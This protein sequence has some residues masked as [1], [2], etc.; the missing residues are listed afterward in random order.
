MYGQSKEDKSKLLDS[1]PGWTAVETFQ[2]EK[3]AHVTVTV[4]SCSLLARGLGRC[5]GN[6]RK[7]RK[8]I[9]PTRN[10]HLWRLFVCTSATYVH[11]TASNWLD[12]FCCHSV[13]LTLFWSLIGEHQYSCSKNMGLSDGLQIKELMI[14]FKQSKEF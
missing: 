4:T 9:L 7:E 14:I 13:F 5:L 3:T 11:L 12:G 8:K 6:K 1:K 10:I 2:R